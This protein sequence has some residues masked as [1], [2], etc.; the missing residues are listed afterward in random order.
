[1]QPRSSA[2]ASIDALGVVKPS[3]SADALA[4]LA[5]VCKNLQDNDLDEWEREVLLTANN[6]LQS[7]ML[8]AAA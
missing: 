1:M 8:S 7:G 4:L 3:S 2:S 5:V 6:Y